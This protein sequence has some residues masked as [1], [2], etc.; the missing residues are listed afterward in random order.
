MGK[1]THTLDIQ[2]QLLCVCTLTYVN[3]YCVCV[4]FRGAFLIFQ[5]LVKCFISSL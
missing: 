5:H 3:V 1:I 2:G 4:H